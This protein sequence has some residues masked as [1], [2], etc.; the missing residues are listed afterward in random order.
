ME[1]HKLGTQA[2]G[3]AGMADVCKYVRGNPKS[4]PV[5]YEEVGIDLTGQ[6]IEAGLGSCAWVWDVLPQ[7]EYDLLLAFQ[8]DQAGRSVY[9]RTSLRGGASGVDFAD[10]LGVMKRPT[11]SERT[12]LLC[13]EVSIEFV[14]MEAA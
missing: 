3:V 8:G 9:L 5:T 6:P 1:R 2:G 4:S 10:F 11:F 14:Q 12:Q 13:Y 7:K